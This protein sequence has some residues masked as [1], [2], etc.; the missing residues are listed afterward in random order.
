MPDNIFFIGLVAQ[1]LQ[2]HLLPSLWGHSK[3]MKKYNL[4]NV[5]KTIVITFAGRSGSYLLQNLLDYHSQILSHPS[6]CLHKLPHYIPGLFE[7]RKSN[8]LRDDNGEMLAALT[9]SAGDVHSFVLEITKVVPELFTDLLQNME[10]LGK[11]FADSFRES[12]LYS[13]EY[14]HYNDVNDAASC[15]EKVEQ[16]GV[17]RDEFIQ[18]AKEILLEHIALH[19]IVVPSDI[20]SLI[21]FSYNL[22]KNKR[23]FPDSPVIVWQKHLSLQNNDIPTIEGIVPN[24]LYITT[25]RCPHESID[26]HLAHYVKL[27]DR[28]PF[29]TKRD[30]YYWVVNNFVQA[31][32]TKALQGPQYVI[33]FEDIHKNTESVLA[34]IC[35]LVGLS[36]EPILNSTTLNGE[37]M[38]FTTYRDDKLITISGM[39]KN[40]KPR[41]TFTALNPDDV[42]L[43]KLLLS[44]CYAEYDY[45][46]ER[47]LKAP[48]MQ[49]C[50][51][52]MSG[53]SNEQTGTQYSKFPEYLKGI[54][55]KQPSRLEHSLKIHSPSKTSEF[56]C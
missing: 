32:R 55:F 4:R 12:H 23:S 1:S 45:E 3:S 19:K 14:D 7:A 6:D 36:W 44:R 25:V 26:S 27:G 15:I 53:F 34:E 38:T 47:P 56:V 24:P 41:S 35:Q 50:I 18:I 16:K 10:P 48:N 11:A 13:H 39:N 51:I 42:L 28:N 54:D 29:K 5:Q 9:L 49:N 43:L 21:F 37:I 30:S 31:I 2:V 17:D 40:L 22:S 8:V 33:R 52:G 20:F 46:I